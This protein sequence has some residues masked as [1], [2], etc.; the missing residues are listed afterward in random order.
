MWSCDQSLV[1]R[2]ILWEKLTY[3]LNF[4]RIWP[5]KPHILK[6]GLGS[7]SII[8]DGHCLWSWN[9]DQR[10]KMVEIKIQKVLEAN[11]NVC[12]SYM[13]KLV[14]EGGAFCSQNPE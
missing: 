1:T 5:E 8:L 7:S 11:C 14:E 13:E 3:N 10:G 12:R 2:A 4:I 9:L 6:G